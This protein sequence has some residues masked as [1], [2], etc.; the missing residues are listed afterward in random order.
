MIN[1]INTPLTDQEL[2]NAHY[3]I[4]FYMV[5]IW[6]IFAFLGYYLKSKKMINKI[7]FLLIFLSFIQEIF[8]YINR[9]FVNDLYQMR[10]SADLPLQLCHISYWFTVVCLIM[11]YFNKKS[12]YL[13]HL[14]SCAYIFGFGAF[15][16]IVTVDLTGIYTLGDMIALNLQHSI[17]VLNLIWLIFCFGLK[18]ELKGIFIAFIFLNF[19]ALIIGVI[20][21]FLNSNYMFLC[22][23]PKV[24]NILI[25]GGWPFY[26]INIELFFIVMGYLLYLPFK[27]VNILNRN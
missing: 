17:I 1:L 23:P 15:Q 5:I 12:K 19:L 16:G 7:T 9:I 6:I 14:F 20:N 24:D 22:S 10:I 4:T 11:I 2:Y 8:D 3:Q 27:V 13:N 25:S 18:L 26:I 21:Y